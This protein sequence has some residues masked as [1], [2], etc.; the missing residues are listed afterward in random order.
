M[1]AIK[2]LSLPQNLTALA[3]DSI[4]RYIME[5]DLDEDARLTEEFL[6]NRLGIS[7]SPV[8]EAL[9]SLQAEGLIR[10]EPRRGAFLRRFSAK[11]IKDLYGLREEL[12][13]YAVGVADLTPQLIA[14]LHTSI[15]HTRSLVKAKNRIGHIEEDTHFHQTIAKASGNAELCR[16]LSNIHNQI[17]LCRCKS[18]SLSSSTAVQ[19]HLKILEAFQKNDRAAAQSHMRM[20]I[21][22][23][24]ERLIEFVTQK[25]EAVDENGASHGSSREIDGLASTAAD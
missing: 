11:E 2:K 17:W 9:N 20:H 18:Y 4:K 8:R 3:Y 7:K 14:E 6:S 1:S 21:A 25:D 13:A 24:R 5:G 15:E 10:I 12:E 19:A 16:V 23:V 22:L